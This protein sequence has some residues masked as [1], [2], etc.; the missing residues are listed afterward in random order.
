MIRLSKI[1][2]TVNKYLDGFSHLVMPNSCLCCKRELSIFEEEICSFCE[3]EL[4]KTYFE[5]FNEPSSLD[6]LFWGRLEVTGTYAMY[7]FIKGNKSQDIL[8][9]IKYQHK[10]SIANSMGKRLGSILEKMETFKGVDLI[11]PVPLHYKKAFIR[12][13]NQSEEIAKGVKEILKIPILKEGIQ[14]RKHTESQTKKDRFERWYN[15]GSNFE[16]V[17]DLIP[18]QHVLLVDDVITT[19]STLEAMGRAI[20]NQFPHLKISIASIALTK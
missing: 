1:A 4:K 9:A 6:K 2:V 12:G 7:Y 3:F 17:K 11:I 18:F 13:Y 14:K 5:G 19:G 20:H 15:V 8:H 16:V 10:K